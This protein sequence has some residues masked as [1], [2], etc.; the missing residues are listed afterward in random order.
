MRMESPIGRVRGL[1]SAKSGT[2]HWWIQRVTAIAMAPLVIWFLASVVALIGADHDAIVAWIRQP[3]VAAL[4]VLLVTTGLYHMRL[5][6]Q[7]V[8][9][10][11]IHKPATKLF[12]L[13]FATFA[14]IVAGAIAII[15]ILTVLFGG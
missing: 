1:G 15:S 4:L 7:V 3:V 12:L 5:G 6:V 10:D 13:L 11:Y 9:E 2:H 14:A 8:V